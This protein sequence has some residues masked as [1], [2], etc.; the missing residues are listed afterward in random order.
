[1]SLP[2]LCYTLGTGRAHLPERLALAAVSIDTL[3]ADLEQAA[4]GADVPRAARGRAPVRRVL[5]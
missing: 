4:R 3:A 1:M 2:D 5:N